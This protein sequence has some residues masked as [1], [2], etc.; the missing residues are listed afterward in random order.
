MA[1]HRVRR[2]TVHPRELSA[3][4]LLIGEA[5][6]VF[7]AT[8]AGAVI[9]HLITVS[10]WQP[11]QGQALP[12]LMATTA[13]AVAV[14]AVLCA[15]NSQLRPD[16][17]AR[18]MSYAWGYFALIVMPISVINAAPV[19]S[20]LVRGAAA[21]STVIFGC[22]LALGL[23]GRMPRWWSWPRAITGALVLNAL[24]ITVA[25]LVPPGVLDSLAVYVGGAV[26]LPAWGLLALGCIT[27]GLRLDIPLWWRIG[28]GLVVI[29][30]ARALLLFTGGSLEFA[31]L[32]FIGVLV[33]LTATCLQTRSLLV[34]RRIAAAEEAERAA[35]DEKAAAERRHEIRNALFALSSVTTL[36][37]PRPD[38]DSITGG[39]SIRAMID[40]ELLRLQ[41][42]VERTAPGPDENT[43]AVDVVLN[44]LVTLRRLSG[45]EITLDCPV[46][47]RVT[48]PTATLA[49]V[50][51]NLLANCA[52]HAA[53]APVHV[54][55]ERTADG[56]MIEIT[57]GGP[58]VD[59]ARPTTGDG[60]G[61]AL[62]M[63][64][65]EAAGGRLELRT[66][67]RFPT[68]TTVLLSLPT[69]AETSRHLVVAP[70]EG[71]LAS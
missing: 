54:G 63:R 25:L 24:S 13:G 34:Q 15:L 28:F 16:V 21:A 70:V 51:T 43:A 26:M 9:L 49:Q 68:G 59:P 46:G 71:R 2:S 55:A 19:S 61:L 45:S 18:L 42:L 35:A 29:C 47:I 64:L 23:V 65:V 57:D 27:R 32:R 44:R 31:T 69:V 41:G 38:A 20:A 3:P 60:L 12:V 58:G 1:L 5:L 36:M 48:L 30:S 4:V 37:T 14:M 33:L 22:L 8:I 53:G 56:C 62:S 11:L 7:C 17:G 39:R 67:T 10:G 52:R 40:D 6:L 50:V 66:A